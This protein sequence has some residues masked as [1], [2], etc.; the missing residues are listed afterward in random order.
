MTR[1]AVPG[2][3]GGLLYCRP[4]RLRL[5]PVLASAVLLVAACSTT[6]SSTGKA[7]ARPDSSTLELG[8]LSEAEVRARFGEPQSL[9]WPLINGRTVKTLSYSY[10]ESPSDVKTVPVRVMVFMFADGILV[11][12]QYLSSFSDDPTDFDETRVG[13][14]TRGQ[15]TAAHVV[16]LIGRPAGEF[17][18]PL[19]KA[20]DGR[21]YVYNY[22]LTQTDAAS[23]RL[24]TRVK[25]LIVNFDTAGVVSDVDLSMT[26]K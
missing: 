20:T 15:T 19:A 4:M 26:G 21:A 3:A 11:G 1:G 25:T 5:G 12:H 6:T 16:D 13:Q 10:A 17:I 2:G 24:T 14:I 9:A 18:H 7:F 23:G 22:S 8:K